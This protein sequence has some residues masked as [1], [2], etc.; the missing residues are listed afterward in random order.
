MLLDTRIKRCRES[1]VAKVI[2]GLFGSKFEVKIREVRFKNSGFVRPIDKIK[3]PETG[4]CCIRWVHV[5]EIFIY[6]FY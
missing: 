1:N 3:V 4:R 2:R 5:I 6:Y